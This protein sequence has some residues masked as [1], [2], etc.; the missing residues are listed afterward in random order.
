M[1]LSSYTF[2]QGTFYKLCEEIANISFVSQAINPSV[3][4]SACD[5]VYPNNPNSVVL[6][7]PI[8]GALVGDVVTIVGIKGKLT[9]S[10]IWIGTTDLVYAYTHVLDASNI[11]S[12]NSISIPLNYINPTY[13]TSNSIGQCWIARQNFIY[14]S[15][16]SPAVSL[17]PITSG[18]PIADYTI[19]YSAV[20][21]YSTTTLALTATLSIFDYSSVDYLVLDF[22][23]NGNPNVY[24]IKANANPQPVEASL[25]GITC[26]YMVVNSSRLLIHFNNQISF[27]SAIFPALAILV[28]NINQPVAVGVTSVNL[29]TYSGVSQ[30]SKEVL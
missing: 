21:T 9:D 28:K 5:T 7:L 25:N 3:D 12:A 17:C 27:P 1:Q 18:H 2:Y 30:S 19:R 8:Q 29:C 6:V 16:Q 24:A 15:M 23:Y 20:T 10:S 14:A 11:I 22:L 4:L 13:V 26:T